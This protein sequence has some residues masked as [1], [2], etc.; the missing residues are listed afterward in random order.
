MRSWLSI[1]LLLFVSMVVQVEAKAR[2]MAELSQATTTVLSQGD[3]HTSSANPPL[4]AI[5]AVSVTSQASGAE[6]LS[7]RSKHPATLDLVWM[8]SNQ[9]QS[10][11]CAPRFLNKT[12]AAP[13]SCRYAVDR[14]VF[15]LRKIII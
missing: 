7:V 5:S 4:F 8:R 10:L 15:A 6:S 12:S 9:R 1:I 3:R 2:P 11:V 13:L 14:Y